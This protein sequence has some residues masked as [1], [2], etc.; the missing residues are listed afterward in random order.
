MSIKGAFERMS[1]VIANWFP[2]MFCQINVTIKKNFFVNKW[3]KSRCNPLCKKS[4][5]SSSQN[6]MFF[7]CRNRKEISLINFVLTS[8]L[9]HTCSCASFINRTFSMHLLTLNIKKS[10]STAYS[11]NNHRQKQENG[12]LLHL[13]SPRLHSHRLLQLYFTINPITYANEY[14]KIYIF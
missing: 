2:F 13:T 4:K 10:E 3:V 14:K 6:V 5:S 11:Q 1:I 7:C 12:L 8:P 9:P